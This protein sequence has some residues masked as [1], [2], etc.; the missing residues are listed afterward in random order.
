M[1][2]TEHKMGPFKAKFVNKNRE[3]DWSN[4]HRVS[5]QNFHARISSHSMTV[6]KIS[7]N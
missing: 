3:F 4:C 7:K 2:S 6:S 5:S 1:I